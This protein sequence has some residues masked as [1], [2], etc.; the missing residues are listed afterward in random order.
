[1]TE[2]EVRGRVRHRRTAA[3]VLHVDLSLHLEVRVAGEEADAAERERGA[4]GDANA[5]ATAGAREGDRPTRRLREAG[6]EGDGTG[7]RAELR[8]V[9]RDAHGE[10]HAVGRN[11]EA[12]GV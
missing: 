3:D 2:I 11:D 8:R 10:G 6:L 7:A 12:R 4:R 1:L 5:R 9:A